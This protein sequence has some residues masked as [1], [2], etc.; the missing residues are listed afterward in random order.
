[1]DAPMRPK[2][3]T[4]PHADVCIHTTTTKCPDDTQKVKFYH[5]TYCK[6]CTKDNICTNTH[7][8]D[9]VG[10][11]HANRIFDVTKH[12]KT[13]TPL[14]DLR[15]L[16][17]TLMKKQGANFFL[18]E[19][20]EECS[21]LQYID[22][23]ADI[24]DDLLDLIIDSLE[25]LTINGE[26]R[27]L[28]NTVSRKVHIIMNLLA[29]SY[30]HSPRKK[31][32]SSWLCS[33]L[34][35]SA[36]ISEWYTED[37]WRTEIFDGNAAGIRSALSVKVKDGKLEPNK[38]VYAP[39]GVD[40]ARLTDK[41]KIDIVVN[42]SIYCEPS[43]RWTLDTLQ[44][45]EQAE[46]TYETARQMMKQKIK[47]DYNEE[48]RTVIFVGGETVICG[49]LL[50]SFIKLLPL[51]WGDKGH[52][53]FTLKQVKTAALL[54]P[55][56]DPAYFLHEWS[57][58]HKN[59]YN[60][61]NNDRIYASCRVEHCNAG[62]A[63]T[64]L[65]NKAHKE[66]ILDDCLVNGHDLNLARV[67]A[68]AT[69]GRI[70][71]VDDDGTCYMWDEK[72]RV[73][74]YRSSKWIANEISC[75]LENLYERYLE[76][77]KLVH[78]DNKKSSDKIEKKTR[79]YKAELARVCSHRTAMNVLYKSIPWLEDKDFIK[80][81]NLQPDLLPIAG[82]L[83]VDLQ[84]G[85]MSQRQ[86]SHNFTFE[87]PVNV[88]RSTEARD[89]V[90]R[91]MLDICCGDTSLL[92]YL[93]VALGY[94]ITGR[95]SEKAV[96]VWWGALG[97]NG[98]STIMNLLKAILG[99]YCKAASKCLFIKTKSDSKLTPEREV[100]KDT[101]LV[102]FSETAADDELNDELLK[103]ASGDD[104]IKV[105]PKYRAE[106]E[107]RPYAKLLI[108]SNHKPRINVSDDAMVRRIKFVPFLT[109]FVDKPSAEHE[110]IKNR[111]LVRLMETEL[112]DAFFTWVL[113][114]AISWY[115]HG[116]VDI[117]I[118]MREATMEF[119]TENDN[120]GSFLSDQ[121]EPEANGFIRSSDL[122][123][124]YTVWCQT[125]KIKYLGLKSFSQEMA[126]RNK[127]GTQ[128]GCSGFT[129]IKFR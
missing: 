15:D 116:L 60:P 55:D 101:R 2:S 105:N 35:E 11:S 94:C 125:H 72:I 44:Q 103:M 119:I 64:W 73:W 113:D 51:I 127:R 89:I 61:H 111:Q 76:K 1:M 59:L 121:T 93:Q 21:H 14:Y 50:M 66:L 24:P 42:Y 12:S 109:K 104:L 57:A 114:G 22:L 86:A 16:A 31:V 106:Y 100:L 108:A 82:G 49:A 38:G 85:I 84:T 43:G 48:K 53:F 120:L 107:F 47:S 75:V 23:D 58:Q 81:I 91:F 9:F 68:D 62:Y 74:Q 92:R 26:V 37:L 78:L 112:L 123:S 6:V 5:S 80:K 83:V 32:I 88:D 34:Y 30:R 98:K 124:S 52:W 97:D 29:S 40:V 69:V 90:H 56:F 13:R 4:L 17:E 63:I 70:K 102:M 45:F 7:R 71:V 28:R 65:R 46:Q 54:A 67:I 8:T 20:P 27:V 122:Y 129:G 99:E 118:V 79:R 10:Y 110:R 117:P 128:K 126:K 18:N 33:H 87:C 115:E 3:H 41:E 19:F 95:V 96:F 77:L 25:C 39:V 36:G